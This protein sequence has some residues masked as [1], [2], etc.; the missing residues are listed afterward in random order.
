MNW[1]KKFFLLFLS[2]FFFFS[3]HRVEAASLAQKLSGR[4][5]LQVEAQGQAYY[6]NPLDLK[7]YYLGRP[8]DAFNLMRSLALGVSNTDLDRFSRQGARPDLSG[9]ILLQVEAQGQAY[10]V[11]PTDFKLRYL[12]RPQDAF[13]LMREMGLGITNSNLNQIPL[14]SLAPPDKLGEKTVKFN[15][16]YQ[17]R[18]YYLYQTFSDSRYASYNRSIKY[19]AYSS[20]KPPLNPRDSYYQIFFQTQAS[21]TALTDLLADLKKVAQ[22]DN[23]NEKEWLEFVLAF[24][25][26]IPYDFSKN[27]NSP[28]NFPYETLYLNSGICSDKAILA[29]SLLRAM[30]YGAAIFDY[31][32]IK[33]SAAA[34][35][36]LEPSSSSGYCFVETTNYFPVGVFPTSLTAGQASGGGSQ[37][38]WDRLLRSETWGPLEIYQKT[39]GRSYASMSET[40]KNIAEM[41]TRQIDL[42]RQKKELN[43]MNSSLA[44]LSGETKQLLE[45]IEDYRKKNEIDNYNSALNVYNAQL[46]R[47]NSLLNSYQGKIENYNRDIV[48]LNNLINNF[49]QV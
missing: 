48:Q 34:V 27:E 35:A 19:L 30:G 17:N 15:W 31:P 23:L 41:K 10:Y 24:V 43:D 36:C 49:W 39:S 4:I 11:N 14:G 2:L 3:I 38:D 37:I 29:V 16:K 20:D 8:V 26:Y 46:S 18:P 13:N 40:V 5:L 28:Q 45:Q 22:I 1:T 21:D 25:Q 42:A 47:Y 9:R 33:H 12:G 32:E 44:A 7:K 6:V